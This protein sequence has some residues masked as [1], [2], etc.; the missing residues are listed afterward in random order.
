MATIAEQLTQ[1]QADKEALVNFLVDN[2][3]KVTNEDTFTTLIP[4]LNGIQTGESG[5]LS[6][7]FATTSV[8]PFI[9]SMRSHVRIAKDSSDAVSIVITTGVADGLPV[10]L[11]TLNLPSLILNHL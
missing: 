11:A 1:L 9:V 8:L 10:R 3:I 7:Y 5:D 4:K 2:E 6:E